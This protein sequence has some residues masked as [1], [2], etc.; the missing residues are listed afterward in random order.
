MP[1]WSAKSTCLHSPEAYSTRISSACYG[2]AYGPPRGNPALLV[3]AILGF[4]LWIILVL[5]TILEPPT[6]HS[7]DLDN[8]PAK[9]ADHAN[10]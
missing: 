3:F 8:I 6:K 9:E 2:Y 1:K 10:P 4:Y 5:P 7:P